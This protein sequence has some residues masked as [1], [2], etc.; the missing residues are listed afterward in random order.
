MASV[1]SPSTLF[2]PDAVKHNDILDIVDYAYHIYSL[3]HIRTTKT[4]SQTVGVV[5]Q[6]PAFCQTTVK[7]S[8]AEQNVYSA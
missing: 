4:T 3:V 1:S 8:K 6:L 5:P 2:T 7:S